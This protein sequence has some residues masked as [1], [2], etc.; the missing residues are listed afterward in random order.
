MK[1]APAPTRLKYQALALSAALLCGAGSMRAATLTVTSLDDSGPGTLRQAILDASPDDT[2]DFALSG[3]IGLTSGELTIG[4]NLNIAGPGA[5]NLTISGNSSNRVFSVTAGAVSLSGLTI[6]GGHV[7]SDPFGPG[8]IGRGA[9]ILNNATLLL[10][11]CVLKNNLVAGISGAGGAIYNSGTLGV[12]R[13]AL[14]SNSANN[15]GGVCN[16]GSLG[17]TNSTLSANTAPSDFYVGEGG[18]IYNSGPLTVISCTLS[19]NNAD[20]RGG[21][22]RHAGSVLTIRHCTFAANSG[23]GV[24][25]SSG[26]PT[27]FNTI[28]ANSYNDLSGAFASAGY[29]LIS[30]TNGATGITNGVNHDLAGSTAAPLDAK[31]GLLADNGGFTKTHAL[32]P[33]SPAID[34][35]DS[36]GATGDQR[37]QPR[38]VDNPLYPNA[39]DG[40]DIGAYEL[41][42][43]GLGEA[44]DNIALAWTTGGNAA[45]GPQTA[46]T[47]DFMDAAQ[48]GAIADN[49]QSLLETTVTGAGVLTFWWKVSSETGADY[50]RFKIDSVEQAAISGEIGWERR[51]Y[52]IG[53]GTHTLQWAYTKNA[54]GSTGLDRGWVD[55]VGFNPGGSPLHTL[56]VTNLGD[57]GPG[58]LRQIILEASSGDMIDFAVG[59]VITLTSGPLG[60]SKSLNIAGP[61]AANLAVRGDG[62]NRVFSVTAGEVNLS[63]LTITGGRVASDPFG[64]GGIGRGAGIYNTG[65]LNLERCVLSNNIVAGISGAGGAVY[66]SGTLG[67]NQCTVQGNSANTGGGVC[68]SGPGNVAFSTLSANIAF[69]DF[70]VGEGGGIYNSGPLGVMASTLSGNSADYAGGA[71]RHAGGSLAIQHSTIAANGGGGINSSSGSPTLFNSIVANAYSDLSG[72]FTSAGY[73][74]ISQTNGATGFTNG[75]NHDVAGNSAAPLDAQLLPLADNG[76]FT[77][78]HA[79][80]LSSPAIDAGASRGAPMDQIGQP[81]VFDW[82]LY[83]NVNDAC[84][85][86]AFENHEFSLAEALDNGALVWLSNGDAVWFGQNAVTRDDFNSAQSGAIADRQQ[87]VLSTTVNGPGKLAFWWKVS[88]EANGDYLRFRDSGVEQGAISGEVDWE[89][90]VFYV[91]AGAHE[92]EWVYTKNASVTAGADSGWLDEVSFAAG[93][94]GPQTLTVTN[95]ADSGSGTL[96]ELVGVAADD[97]I[98]NFGVPGTITLTSGQLVIGKH[99]RIAGPGAANVTISGNLNQRIFEIAARTSVRISGLKLLNGR[100]ANYQDGGAVLNAGTLALDDC[101]V[102]GNRA[103]DGGGVFN[104]GSLTASNCTISANAITYDGYGGGIY[105]S[106][107]SVTLTACAIL[108]NSSGN[109]ISDGGGIYNPRGTLTANKCV[110][111]GNTAYAGG[112]GGI[113]TGGICNISDS[114]ISGNVAIAGGGFLNEG[115]SAALSGCTLSGNNAYDDDGGGLLSFGGPTAL[116]LCTISE[117]SSDFSGGGIACINGVSLTS[118]TVVSNL[119]YDGGGIDGAVTMQNTILAGN[120]THTVAGHG[121]D[122]RGTITSADYNL[123]QQTNDCA[124]SGAVTHNLIGLD[125]RLGVLQDN[126]EPTWTHALLPGSPAIDA[127]HSGG[128]ATDQRG[129]PRT[130][131]FP[132]IPNA[133]G[134]DGSDIGA[135]ELENRITTLERV[136]ADVRVTF[137]TTTNQIYRIEYSPVLPASNWTA[138]PD[139]VTGINGSMS[140]TNFGA[141]S[142]ARRFY[143]VRQ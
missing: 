2:I 89:R 135:F 29:N 20:Y 5:A 137:I 23:G 26:A 109:D 52:S 66:S 13:C 15:G 140:V 115:G 47:H 70:Y 100:P 75:I 122:A 143:R 33:G 107:G 93:N 101:I 91:G 125:P 55:Q 21:A 127:G 22:I 58:T 76:G 61:G 142:Q 60:I 95:L 94:T 51:Y 74:L 86:G 138:L 77:R 111:S 120:A 68:N 112:G 131:D 34:A 44:L 87:S 90:R 42:E 132:A 99:L 121:P 16:A 78:T 10:D 119:A 48:S 98:I 45:W 37:G 80:R 104:S 9:G 130:I 25:S 31:L 96:R 1:T 79:V 136:G 114:T 110:I 17:L 103:Y 63:G 102:A 81:R 56:T 105:N 67:L 50:L 141:A 3:T 64:P 7:A 134:G 24:F 6:S 32:L 133:A 84:D 19:G 41:Q 92:L 54:S 118:C 117:N 30:Q 4:K 97:D 71:I 139:I 123:I 49:Q 126:G 65:S 73:N 14:E 35:G 38:T 85:I 11:Q 27:L 36:N 57:S 116:R 124:I 88:S 72:A 53:A 69:S 39:G 28:L 62:S 113:Y 8:G 46:I 128:L 106:G 82:A 12:S 18:G 40:T 59:G 129:H 108:G 43:F 83:P